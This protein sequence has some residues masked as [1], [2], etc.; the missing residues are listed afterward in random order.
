MEH[1]IIVFSACVLVFFF[2][3]QNR[4][5][6]TQELAC[7]GNNHNMIIIFEFRTFNTTII[8]SLI[9]LCSLTIPYHDPISSFQPANL[10]TVVRGLLSVSC[11]WQAAQ[12]TFA[13]LIMPTWC[14]NT[15][16]LGFGLFSFLFFNRRTTYLTQNK[17]RKKEKTK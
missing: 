5:D 16:C 7:R 15:T 13:L 10:P 2:W 17:E 1:H 3:L 8:L 11:H 4:N 6:S 12:H 9:C 14:S